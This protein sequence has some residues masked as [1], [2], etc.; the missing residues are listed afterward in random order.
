VPKK[1]V[2]I[3]FSSEIN[4]M[5]T[6]GL[7]SVC[8]QQAG[9]GVTEVNLLLSSPGGG[10]AN[11]ITLYNVLRGMPFKL[12]T[13]NV[14]AVNS[15]GNVVFLAGEERYATPTSSFMFHGVGFDVTQPA[16]FEEKILRE[17]LDAINND[18]ALIGRIIADRTGIDAQEVRS[19]FLE[20]STK[21]VTFA[22]DKG[23]IHDIRELQIPA[24]VPILQLAFQRQRV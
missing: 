21:D 5:T 6:E 15:I 10:T 20:A 17:R 8:A 9:Q 12:I 7:L 4:P 3:S 22:K 13:Y 14:G 23:I 1:V 16:R 19:L 24:G 18:Q 2:Y 11:G